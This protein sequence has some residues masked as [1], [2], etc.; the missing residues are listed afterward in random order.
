M[1]TVQDKV[2]SQDLMDFSRFLIW[3]DN[4]RRVI[5]EAER[6]CETRIARALSHLAAASPSGL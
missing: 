1:L 4:A 5:P 2:A 3:S 6:H